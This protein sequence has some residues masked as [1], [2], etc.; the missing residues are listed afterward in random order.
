MN[1]RRVG[2]DREDEAAAFLAK[3]G[4]KIVDRN[5]SCRLGEIDI[6]ARDTDYLVFVE[7]KY[8]KTAGAGY[9]EEAVGYTK[10]KKISRA[11]YNYMARKRLAEDT[12]VRFDVVAIEG[13]SIRWHQNA[14]EFTL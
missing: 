7:V 1:K 6:I 12:K 4:L 3:Q 14:F 11:A 5:Y 8:K 9:P 10:A 2:S 13:E